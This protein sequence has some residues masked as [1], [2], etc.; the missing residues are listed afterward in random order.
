MRSKDA[1]QPGEAKYRKN[2][3]NKSDFNDVIQNFENMQNTSCYH[4][5]EE[6]VDE[7]L[8]ADASKYESKYYEEQ[9][10]NFYPKA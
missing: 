5:T 7:V 2:S 6:Q 9:T 8:Y 4:E 10:F 1:S 3:G